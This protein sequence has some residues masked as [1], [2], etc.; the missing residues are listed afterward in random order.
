MLQ[1]LRCN[2]LPVELIMTA[3]RPLTQ[4]NNAAVA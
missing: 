3:Q 1:L 4:Q 2:A